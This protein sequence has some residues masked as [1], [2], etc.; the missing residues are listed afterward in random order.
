MEL[1]ATAIYWDE[2]H[3]QSTRLDSLGTTNAGHLWTGGRATS[4]SVSKVFTI[5]RLRIKR[6]DLLATRTLSP[7]GLYF[8]FNLLLSLDSIPGAVSGSNT[9]L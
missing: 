1:C 6:L 8:G 9:S 2:F 3:S 5:I 4:K 7:N